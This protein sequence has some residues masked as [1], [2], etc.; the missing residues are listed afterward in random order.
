MAGDPTT[1]V[2]FGATGDLTR[3]K[4]IPAL[5]QLACKGR[6]LDQL[7]IVG[8]ARQE[9]SDDGF[10]E[11]MGESVK[12]FGGL[13][14]RT[15]EWDMFAENISYVRGDLETPE[16][17]VRLKQWL[18]HSEG[19]GGNRLFYLS[20]AHRF[21]GSAIANLGSSGL[22]D[23]DGGWRRIVIEK[24]FGHDL[25]PAQALNRAVHAVFDEEQV[26]RID[27]IWARRRCRTFWCSGSATAYSNPHGTGSTWTTFKS[28]QRKLSRSA[29]G[30]DTTTNLAW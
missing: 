5:F 3:R 19:G 16:D 14:L 11:F 25:E 2:I 21:F 27:I 23:K 13:A 15:G 17:Y 9:Y 30:P 6:L 12:E 24:P 10:R 20:V 26:Y 1:I 7:R 29:T 8:F 4:L 22:G 18:D 28:P